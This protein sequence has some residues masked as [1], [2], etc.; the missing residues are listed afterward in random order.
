MRT[1]KQSTLAFAIAAA[2]S[3]AP[4]MAFEPG[5]SIIEPSGVYY[6]DGFPVNVPVTLAVDLYNPNNGNCISSAING[7]TV[8]ASLNEV[9][10][11][12]HSTNN[13]NL[14]N[15]CPATYGFNWS[16]S[17]PGSYNLVV[18][19]RH[20]NDEGVA[21]EEVEFLTLAVEYPAPPAVAN[22][23]INSNDHLRALPGRQRGC[24]ISGVAEKHA[25]LAGTIDGYGPK[26]GP[27]NIDAIHMDVDAFF[28]TCAGGR[29]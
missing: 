17:Q 12:I 13:P 18:T 22:A 24:V 11:E 28:G 20:G 9:S 16:V 23:Y 26:G 19:V 1:L 7:I 2:I 15:V 14:G 21:I 25:K 27:Y 4:A 10:N 3:A 29:R 8:E 5:I 6:V